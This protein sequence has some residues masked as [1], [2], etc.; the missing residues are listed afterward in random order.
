[1]TRPDHLHMK[2]SRRDPGMP[3]GENR[4]R[5]AFFDWNLGAAGKPFRQQTGENWRHVL[6]HDD[7]NGKVF[8]DAR[9]DFR[10]G[11]RTAG[12]SSDGHN[13]DARVRSYP[14][15]HRRTR[16]GS[17]MSFKG[18]VPHS[19]LILGISSARMRSIATAGLPVLLGLVA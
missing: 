16:P 3:G 7:R 9:Q 13:F 2:I 14:N 1:M 18:T 11:V 6:H 10:Q 17:G 5:T 15:L 8:R 19:A 4:A 12:R